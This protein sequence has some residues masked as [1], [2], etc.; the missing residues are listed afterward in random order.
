MITCRRA[1]AI[2]AALIALFLWPPI[3]LGGEGERLDQKIAVKHDRFGDPLP[4]GAIGR[5]GTVRFR[6]GFS[7]YRIAISPDG[8]VLASGGRF[9]GL[10]FW[11]AATG[12]LLHEPTYPTS[13]Y[14]MAFSPDGKSL[15]VYESFFDVA[16]GKEVR[17]LN[18][19]SGQHCVAFSPD[20]TMVAADY[21]SEIK[22]W[23][24]ASGEKIRYFRG[25][26][27]G[28]N[29]LAFSP[30]GKT[31]ASASRDKTMRVWD[32]GSGK[33][34]HRF[35]EKGEVN[36][37]AF[38]PDG[39]ILAWAGDEPA[40]RLWRL[41]PSE[42]PE[43][44]THGVGSVFALAFSP[45]GKLIAHGGHDGTLSLWDAKKRKLQ[46]RW[47]AHGYPVSSIAFFPDGKT[48][49]SAGGMDGAIRVWDTATGTAIHPRVGHT[50]RVEMLR[51]APDGKTLRSFARD[52]R[53]LEWDVASAAEKKVF[54]QR[55]PELPKSGWPISMTVSNDFK[56]L[57]V[58]GWY[59]SHEK[60][61]ARVWLCDLG[62][63]KMLGIL[64]RSGR[65]TRPLELSY[66]NKLVAA[67]GSEGIHLWDAGTG[68]ELAHMTHDQVYVLAFSPGGKFLASAG[69][70]GTVRLWDLTT[71]KQLQNWQASTAGALAR[72]VFSA[73]DHLLVS[74]GAPIGVWETA[75]GRLFRHFATSESC[76]AVALSRSG[77]L[78]A[79]ADLDTSP[80]ADGDSEY[81]AG[82]TVWE[83]I[84]GQAIRHFESKDDWVSSLEFSPDGRVLAAGMADSTIRL[85]G[86]TGHHSRAKLTP[87]DLH[88]HWEALRGAA[89]QAA[90]AGWALAAAPAQAIPFLKERLQPA[91][92]ADPRKIE[93]WLGD[94]KSERFSVRDKA[95]VELAQLGELAEKP[96]R[97]AIS[98]PAV[99]DYR[100]RVERLLN[101]LTEPV[102]DPERL[103][104]VRAVEVLETIGTA[105]A[106]NLLKTL[107]SGAPE[108][109]LTREARTS[110][111]RLDEHR[112]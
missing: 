5:L 90:Q 60:R 64:K 29:S 21:G 109:L 9:P 83:M 50:S 72:M 7:T 33:E 3:V 59:D 55:L 73:D 51:F 13:V 82:V 65:P 11:E 93:Q 16:S 37:V 18:G 22:Q 32:V 4:A 58:G 53:A 104:L 57:A 94:L 42:A 78:L 91:Q 40:I 30:T 107:E 8:K 75:T 34:L 27:R 15:L 19:D 35:T 85:W 31:M 68:A 111:L 45:D 76:T 100:R 95:A 103:R 92:P 25:H 105:E 69:S 24:V 89:P 2:L 14:G 97:Q 43:T 96:L 67:G 36:A 74:P 56:M 80:R 79:G 62:T 70:E 86:L 20:G 87:Q 6:H 106:G 108:A 98:V 54:V 101:R 88:R 28:L 17:R 66:D 52:M 23:K 110:R 38:S 71:R 84:S 63:G 112:R 47:P 48:L 41:D 39:K 44:L 49:A 99:A 81:V 77:R 102:I 46:R 26:S 61:D 10:R 12:R 1:K